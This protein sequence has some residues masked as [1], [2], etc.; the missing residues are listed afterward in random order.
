MCREDIK[1]GRIKKSNV[2]VVSQITGAFV[3]RIGAAKDRTRIVFASP[4][5]VFTVRPVGIDVSPT[6]GFSVSA[7]FSPVEFDIEHHGDMVTWNWEVLRVG[8]G[9]E[10][11]IVETYF[12]DGVFP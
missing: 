9:T 1:I 6:A 8:A 4:A 3:Q 2:Y 7:L 10:L 5:D 12:N 11:V